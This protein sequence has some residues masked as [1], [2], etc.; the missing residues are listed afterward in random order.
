MASSLR[1]RLQKRGVGH[2]ISTACD[3]DVSSNT[4]L[5][6]QEDVKATLTQMKVQEPIA[7]DDMSSTPP[8][9]PPKS[10]KEMLTRNISPPQS[11]LDRYKK[12]AAKLPPAGSQADFGNQP[13]QQPIRLVSSFGEDF[14]VGDSHDPFGNRGSGSPTEIKTFDGVQFDM[15]RAKGKAGEAPIA[16]ISTTALK[17]E[18]RLTRS[19]SRRQQRM[20]SVGNEADGQDLTADKAHLAPPGIATTSDITTSRTPSPRSTQQ[21]LAEPLTSDL[22]DFAPTPSTSPQNSHPSRLPTLPFTSGGIMKSVLFPGQPSP[23]DESLSPEPLTPRPK[24]QPSRHAR[25]RSVTS[26][27]VIPPARFDVLP[28]LV[29]TSGSPTNSR[30]AEP[31]L[32]SKRWACCQC[33]PLDPDNK[34]AQTIVEQKVCSRLDCGH[35]RCGRGCTVAYTAY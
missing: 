27:P 2:D 10:P 1:R 33:G 34:A 18:P 24:P 31:W 23:A 30:P 20:D 15:M 3:G 28:L 11:L 6:S 25:S 21:T 19:Q 35:Q 26:L 4:S 8:P 12:R 16:N 7:S 29:W 32:A 17:Y 13:Q 5:S 9:P 22:D 14:E